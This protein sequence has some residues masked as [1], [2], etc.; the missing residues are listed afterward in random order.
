MIIA[1]VKRK[2]NI[3][4]YLLY[5]FQI[6][7][8]L[9]ANNLDKDRI[10]INIVAKFEQPSE[11]MDEIRAWYDGLTD[12]MIEEGIK[13]KGHLKFVH[14][15]IADLTRLHKKLLAD[16]YELK[17]IE[18]YNWAK[19]NIEDFRRKSNA[20]DAGDIEV[21]LNGLYGFLILKLQQKPISVETAEAMQ[22]FSNLLA[23][24][25]KRFRENR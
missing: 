7:D 17:Y 20:A 4:E 9:R 25:A 16:P 19:R 3:A 24:L 18:Q 10:R 15:I 5:M 1:S 14:D 22:T 11:I 12:S 23:M 6:E 21:C 2:E 13:E 8:I